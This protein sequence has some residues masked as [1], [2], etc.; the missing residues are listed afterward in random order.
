MELYRGIFLQHG[1]DAPTNR[2]SKWMDDRWGPTPEP[3]PASDVESPPPQKKKSPTPKKEKNEISE[4]A[5]AQNEEKAREAAARKSAKA[6]ETTRRKAEAAALKKARTPIG[7]AIQKR[8]ARITPARVK[9][10]ER[11]RYK[12]PRVHDPIGNDAPYSK[13]PD[14]RLVKPPNKV[15]FVKPPAA[16]KN[17]LTGSSGGMASKGTSAALKAKPRS[18]S[19]PLKAKPQ[20]KTTPLMRVNSVK[21]ATPRSSSPLKARAP[22]R[23]RRG[24][25]GR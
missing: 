19:S 10:A 22:A 6:E 15:P 18:H 7:K 16:K 23:K 25:G 12:S 21:L 9:Q 20:K 13:T 17:L 8:K 5:A 11:A 24:R 1:M 3:A 14:K 2:I 4:E